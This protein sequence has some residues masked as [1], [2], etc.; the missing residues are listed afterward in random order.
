MPGHFRQDGSGDGAGLG[1]RREDHRRSVREKQAGN[2]I[3]GFVAQSAI[4]EVNVPPRQM[5][6]PEYGD[7]ARAGRIMSA[8]EINFR[9]PG[10]ALQPAGPYG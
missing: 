10:D 3:D 5:R 9:L 7:F 4:N 1:R 8:V 6:L 2:F